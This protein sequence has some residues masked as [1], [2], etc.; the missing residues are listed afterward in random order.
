MEAPIKYSERVDRTEARSPTA[1][2]RAATRGAPRPC[3]RG[4]HAGGRRARR[5]H[6]TGLLERPPGRRP[7]HRTNSLL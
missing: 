3:A 7:H 2:E 6:Q 4:P 1:A 5:H